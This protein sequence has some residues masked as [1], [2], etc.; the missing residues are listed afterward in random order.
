MKT[1]K[2]WSLTQ[3][4]PHRVVLTVEERHQ[5][6]ISVLE[7]TLFRISLKRNGAWSLDKTWSIAPTQDVP[8]SGRDRESLEGFSL[9][10]FEVDNQPDCIVIST[11]QLRV[12]V[13]HPLS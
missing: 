5:L 4:D 3:T 1:L 8:W 13:Q 9:P 10:A 11:A 7:P 12:T 2:N 6:C